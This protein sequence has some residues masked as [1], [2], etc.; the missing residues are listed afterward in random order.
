MSN[1][2]LYVVDKLDIVHLEEKRIRWF[3]LKKKV[4]F[5][6]CIPDRLIFKQAQTE[7]LTMPILANNDVIGGLVSVK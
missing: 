6:S 7:C 1:E 2:A 3:F 5:D 4:L